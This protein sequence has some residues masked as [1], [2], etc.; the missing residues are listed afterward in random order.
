LRDL[1]DYWDGANTLEVYTG[2][3][4]QLCPN[5][6]GEKKNK[7]DFSGQEKPNA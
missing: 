1:C 6:C 4:A 2:R 5:E 7:L 3:N